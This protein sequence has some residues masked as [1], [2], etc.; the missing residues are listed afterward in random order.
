M[1]RRP[2]RSTQSRAS[3]ASDVY[4]RQALCRG[5]LL[6]R[7]PGRPADGGLDEL[8]RLKIDET[9]R[10]AHDAA[11]SEGRDEVP[12]PGEVVDAAQGRADAGEHVRVAPRGRRDA[13]ALR[14]ARGELVDPGESEARVE[15]LE[16]VDVGD[17]G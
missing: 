3:A 11:L 15:H 4:K 5:I 1:I 7:A 10:A 12:R 13:V 14:E 16:H 9:P 2:P 17:V 8:E 6:P